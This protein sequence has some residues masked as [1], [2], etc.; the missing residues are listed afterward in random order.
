MVALV[1]TI[2]VVII[3]TMGK[4]RIGAESRIG[5]YPAMDVVLGMTWVHKWDST[6]AQMDTSRRIQHLNT[7]GVTEQHTIRI[8]TSQPEVK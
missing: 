1:G 2:A 4:H 8:K 6:S 5:T 7:D 3:I